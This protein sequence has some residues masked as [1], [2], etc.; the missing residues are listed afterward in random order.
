MP[1]YQTAPV[2]PSVV[3]Q[4]NVIEGSASTAI[5]PTAAFDTLGQNNKIGDITSSS[6]SLTPLLF[7]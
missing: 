1:F 3:Q 5:T 7:Y 2:L 4:Q 6:P